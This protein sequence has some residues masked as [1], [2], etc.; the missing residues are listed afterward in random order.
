DDCIGIAARPLEIEIE[1]HSFLRPVTRGAGTA[2]PFLAGPVAPWEAGAVGDGRMIAGC[3]LGLDESGIRSWPSAELAEL[4]ELPRNTELA[5]GAGNA[6]E[7]TSRTEL[8]Q[9]ANRAELTRGWSGRHCWTDGIGGQTLRVQRMIHRR[10]RSSRT[11]RRARV[12]SGWNWCG[13]RIRDGGN[14][15]DHWVQGVPGWRRIHRGPT[16]RH[17]Q[18]D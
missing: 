17:R 12:S 5:A 15:L 10:Q 16:R 6:A 14:G 9:L 18:G 8:S 4:T 13:L 11:D 7:L 3:D 1:V 2:G